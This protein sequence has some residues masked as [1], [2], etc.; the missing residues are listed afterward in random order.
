MGKGKYIEQL[1]RIERLTSKEKHCQNMGKGST[2]NY[3]GS[4]KW[5]R[6]LIW[7]WK[8]GRTR[9]ESGGAWN[10]QNSRRRETKRGSRVCGLDGQLELGG[11]RLISTRESKCLCGNSNLSPK[12]KEEDM[13]VWKLITIG[14]FTSTSAYEQE[15]SKQ[16]NQVHMRWKI[17]RTE[18][19]GEDHSLPLAYT[20]KCTPN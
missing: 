18:G 19:V 10:Y 2:K 11:N 9:K 16:W 17:V 1:E 3:M 12:D 13:M 6:N 14:L 4:G 20:P 15:C 7:E 5:K 8:L